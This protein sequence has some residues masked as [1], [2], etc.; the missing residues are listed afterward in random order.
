[1][2]RPRKRVQSLAWNP[3]VWVEP[4]PARPVVTRERLVRQALVLLD[5]VGFEG[6]TMR[7]LAERLGVQAASLYNHVRDKHELLALLGDAICGEVHVPDARRPWRAQI[8]AVA[9]DYRRV[10]LAHRD[11]ARVLVATPPAGPVR[12]RLIEHMLAVL[13]AAG[14]DDETVV[15]AATVFN[16]YVVG[17]VLDETQALPRGELADVAAEEFRRGFKALPAERYPTIAALADRL[18]D[19]DTDRRFGFGLGALLDGLE[20]RLG[21]GHPS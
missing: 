11:A 2:A 16:T 5:E 10:L 1:M 8:E 12:L 6:L 4:A 15:D 7:R 21:A 17:F 19:A 18:L 13:R 3:A 20:R 14:F 9:W